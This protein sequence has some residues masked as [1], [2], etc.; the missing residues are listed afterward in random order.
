MLLDRSSQSLIC[1]V[2]MSSSAMNLYSFDDRQSSCNIV[3]LMYEEG[4]REERRKD[5]GLSGRTIALFLRVPRLGDDF[6]HF[7]QFPGGISFS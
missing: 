6:S 5:A 1:Q 2:K 4:P 7:E 3:N